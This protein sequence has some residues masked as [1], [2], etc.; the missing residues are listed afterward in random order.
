MFALCKRRVG[1]TA[2]FWTD[3]TDRNGRRPTS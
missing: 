3:Q 1:L 2:A